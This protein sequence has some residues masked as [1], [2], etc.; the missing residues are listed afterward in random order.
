M[1]SVI[2]KNNGKPINATIFQTFM[3]NQKCTG[4]LPKANFIKK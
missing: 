3:S 1:V 4:S 2:I